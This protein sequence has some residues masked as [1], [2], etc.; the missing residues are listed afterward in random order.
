[1]DRQSSLYPTLA[2]VVLLALGTVGVGCSTDEPDSGKT[3]IHDP[4][5]H[6]LGQTYKPG[7]A[8]PAPE[9]TRKDYLFISSRATGARIGATIY[10]MDELGAEIQVNGMT[11][12]TMP[13]PTGTGRLDFEV[14]GSFFI[15]GVNTVTIRSL[16]RGPVVEDFEYENLVV[17]IRTSTP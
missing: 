11:A 14:D 5:R 16:P 9:G 3:V 1:L 8:S 10:D 6:H 13:P 17:E 4:Q 15:D 7:Y 12:Y 2:L